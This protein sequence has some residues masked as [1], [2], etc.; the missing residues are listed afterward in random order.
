MI[1]VKKNISPRLNGRPGLKELETKITELQSVA[2]VI[3]PEGGIYVAVLDKSDVFS[4]IYRGIRNLLDLE[5]TY[6]YQA[7]QR[8]PEMAAEF[9][10]I[11]QALNTIDRVFSARVKKQIKAREARDNNN[12]KTKE[13]KD[14]AWVNKL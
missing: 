7:L 8:T 10:E 1:K 6:S 13:V 9:A 4:P 5:R 12:K 11:N 2:D 3:S 14:N